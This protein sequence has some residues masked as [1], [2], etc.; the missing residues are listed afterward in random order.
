MCQI[1]RINNY[2]D[3]VYILLRNK[4][5][6]SVSSDNLETLLSNTDGNHHS[7]GLE[8][9]LEQSGWMMSGVMAM[10]QD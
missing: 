9:E 7:A 5:P 10:N 2:G 4:F 3:Y 6:T 1:L 8:L